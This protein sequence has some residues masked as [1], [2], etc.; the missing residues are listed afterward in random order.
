MGDMRQVKAMGAAGERKL[1]IMTWGPEPLVHT[2]STAHVLMGHW[3]V[4]T[5][6]VQS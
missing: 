6:S 5:S 2:L 4:H 3:C 1:F